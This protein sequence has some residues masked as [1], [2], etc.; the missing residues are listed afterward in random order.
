MTAL[1][2]IQGVSHDVFAVLDQWVASF[3]G[4]GK[5]KGSG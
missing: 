3:A 5:D 1:M 4:K 2:T